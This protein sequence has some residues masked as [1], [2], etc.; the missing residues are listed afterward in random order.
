L[1]GLFSLFFN[2]QLRSDSV[3]AAFSMLSTVRGTLRYRAPLAIPTTPQPPF[4]IILPQIL[5][6]TMADSE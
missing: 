3:Q 1:P 6:H 2:I 5:T 4:S